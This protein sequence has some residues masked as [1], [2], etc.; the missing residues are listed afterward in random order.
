MTSSTS[1]AH[2]VRRS[3]EVCPPPAL[4][5]LADAAA[6]AVGADGA[7]TYRPLRFDDRNH[8]THVQARGGARFHDVTVALQG[9]PIEDY[10][11]PTGQA[12]PQA[13][14]CNLYRV[15]RWTLVGQRVAG[16]LGAWA[17]H[18][19]PAGICSTIGLTVAVGS[20]LVGGVVL[21]RLADA[22]P[23]QRRDVA[24]LERHCPLARR[25]G[26]HA[27]DEADSGEL[28]VLVFN[29][30]GEMLSASAHGAGWLSHPTAIDRLAAAAAQLAHSGRVE[31]LIFAGEARF[32]IERLETRPPL[33]VAFPTLGRPVV[34]GA[35][36]LLTKAQ[37]RVA[38]L[39]ALGTTTAE[40]ARHLDR[41]PNTVHHHLKGIYE[42]LGI[43]SRAEL[44][45][46]MLQQQR[47][48]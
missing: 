25:F 21:V 23:F 40:I 18:W 39:A 6:A 37:M 13:D 4:L 43:G 20:V 19:R 28:S 5:R 26:A 38:E 44:T 9:A 7:F 45:R 24:R 47:A 15:S 2:S 27:I 35:R 22:E 33:F 17:S 30:R 36:S 32:R 14:T 41:S 48:W 29:G 11:C 34:L 3:P 16:R 46:H 42:R 1:T 10:S 12:D 31:G 8:F